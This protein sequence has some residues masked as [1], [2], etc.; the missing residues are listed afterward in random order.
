METTTP[1]SV[2]TTPR[3]Q[4]TAEHVRLLTPADVPAAAEV[5]ARAFE[6]DAALKVLAPDP[7]ARHRLAV[8]LGAWYVRTAVPYAS[9]WG[10]DTDDGLQ[11]V[12]VWHP[13]SVS[14][15]S[16]RATLTALRE[17]RPAARAVA[18]LPVHVLRTAG[19][20]P[21]ALATLLRLQARSR[22][23]AG[24]GPSW[25]LAYLAVAPEA[26]G[27]GLARR[28]LDHVLRRCDA[29]GVA[30]WLQTTDPANVPLY[31]R[32]GFVTVCHRSPSRRVPG[33]WVMRREAA[34]ELG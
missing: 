8:W 25:Y 30:A 4:P 29:D 9:V 6:A 7:E 13:P 19:S 14:P 21:L 11:A 28:L 2:M 24:A 33:L 15:G 34:L 32:F 1:L 18:G 27:R 22:S 23:T 3:P 26:Q 10:I 31:E 20:E 5:I 17:A 12:A 16:L